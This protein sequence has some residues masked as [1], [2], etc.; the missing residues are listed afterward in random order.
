MIRN[1]ENGDDDEED[2]SRRRH[3]RR[4]GNR[5]K[6]H[7]HDYGKRH[8]KSSGTNNNVTDAEKAEQASGSNKR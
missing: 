3:G 8:S 6:R 5:H 2:N 7:L 4:G 1:E